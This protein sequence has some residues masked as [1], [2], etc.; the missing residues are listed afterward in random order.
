MFNYLGKFISNLLTVG[1]VLYELLRSE[2]V[3]TWDHPQQEAFHQ[4]KELLSASP[5]LKCY[6]IN[7]PTAILADAAGGVLLQLHNKDWKP[8]AYCSRCLLDAATRYAQIEKECLASV[9]A[10]EKFKKY[11]C[12]LENFKL[13]TDHKPLV[14]LMNKKDLDNVPIWCQRLLMRLMRFRPTHLERL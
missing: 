2:S 5:V 4:I 11:L 14:L 9:W 6:D 1:Q 10:C 8:V 3:W 13:V 12:G 7:R